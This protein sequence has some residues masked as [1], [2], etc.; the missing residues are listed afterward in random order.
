MEG[1]SQGA[2]NRIE[3]DHP[4]NLSHNG[5]IVQD[6]FTYASWFTSFGCRHTPRICHQVA[7]TLADYALF[8]DVL[9]YGLRTPRPCGPYPNS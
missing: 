7:D 1:D 9:M 5:F 3:D 2:I 8:H 6:V 4:A